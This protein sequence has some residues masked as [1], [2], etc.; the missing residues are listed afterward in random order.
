MRSGHIGD[1]QD[2]TLSG[3]KH[4]AR[5]V[6]TNS[7]VAQ[8]IASGTRH[9]ELFQKEEAPEFSFANAAWF[10]SSLAPKPLIEKKKGKKK[11]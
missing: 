10:R 5:S 3:F 7:A 9:P 8:S 6:D 4:S 11:C 2:K 1:V